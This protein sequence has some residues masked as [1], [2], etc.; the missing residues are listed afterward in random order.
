MGKSARTT[1][2]IPEGLKRQMG[3]IEEPV[4]W[5]VDL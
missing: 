1:M 3:A 5:N 4:N 2:T